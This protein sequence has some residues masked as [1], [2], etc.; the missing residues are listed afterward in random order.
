MSFLM[1][2]FGKAFGWVVGLAVVTVMFV[3]INFVLV[4][5]QKI[6]HH[7]DQEK[8]A[9]IK[10]ELDYE[11][12]ALEQT[13][14]KLKGLAVEMHRGDAESETL[15]IKL[16]QTEKRYPKGIPSEIYGSYKIS[17]SRYNELSGEHNAV[18]R[19]YNVLYDSYSG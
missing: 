17:I 18:L 4:G 10:A 16:D 3:V 9:L 13:E 7:A 15:K 12:G 6:W 11:R 2:M 5:A 14:A 19:A 1:N 8:L